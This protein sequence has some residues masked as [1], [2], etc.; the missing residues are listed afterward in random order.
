MI[1]IAK[2][3]V[4]KIIKSRKHEIDAY[5]NKYLSKLKILRKENS[6][7]HESQKFLNALIHEFSK[8]NFLTIDNSSF[9]ELIE[10]VGMVPKFRH[11]FH[12]KKEPSYFKDEILNVL[13]YKGLRSSFFPL[14]FKELDIKACVYCNSQLTLAVEKANGEVSAKFQLDHYYPKDQ[15]PYLSI[16]LFNLY[17]VCA[18]CNLS[19]SN[20][21]LQ[22]VLYDD[23]LSDNFKFKIDKTSKVKFLLTKNRDDLKIEFEG[24]AA[25]EDMFNI[26]AI[27]E[28]QVDVAEE[29]VIKSL[30]YNESYRKK[31]KEN[32]LNNKISD[33]LIN[34]YILGNYVEKNKIHKRPMSKFMQD[35]GKDIGLI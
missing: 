11:R 15:Y 19:K 13:N 6:L 23:N 4:Y 10:R 32:F 35:I 12:N 7:N 8:E 33:S 28:T 25:F 2:E 34:R 18:S 22:F 31:L 24:D 9:F 16:A 20:N 30:I 3:N 27:Y 5:H 26:N 17:P 29:I 21:P 1:S 14:L